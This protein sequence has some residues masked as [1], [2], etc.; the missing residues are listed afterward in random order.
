MRRLTSIKPR[1]VERIGS[2]PYAA[3]VL[4]MWLNAPYAIHGVSPR[5]PTPWSRKYVNLLGEVYRGHR[6]GFF[7]MYR[8]K[9]FWPL[10]Q[11]LANKVIRSRY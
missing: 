10:A 11:R 8:P 4:V 2:I 9:G 7:Q 3:N 1:Y 6:E 5:Q